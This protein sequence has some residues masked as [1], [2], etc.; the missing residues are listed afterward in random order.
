MPILT[1]S[2][3]VRFLR[4]L[5]PLIAI[6]TV[7]FIVLLPV[8][9][10]LKMRMLEKS[11]MTGLKA[12]DIA[13][14]RPVPGK[15]TQLQVTKPEFIGRDDQNHP[16]IVKAKRVLQDVAL[17]NIKQNTQEGLVYL[18][19]PDAKMI[20]NETSG[21]FVTVKADQGEYDAKAQALRLTGAV[22]FTDENNTVMHLQDLHVLLREGMAQT[23]HAVT[24][25]GSFGNFQAEALE[26][27]DKGMYLILKGRSKVVLIPQNTNKSGEKE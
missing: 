12:E 22:E 25:S 9:R 18:E 15:P 2:R 21:Q 5:L 7:L 4:R 19:G 17:Q 11:S 10:D 26:L 24:G 20:L 3:W 8:Y 14:T 13:L 1:Y 23:D 6:I 27:R 16:F